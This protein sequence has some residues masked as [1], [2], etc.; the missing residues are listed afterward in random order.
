MDS[1]LAGSSSARP[2]P[3]AMQSIATLLVH[4]A[5]GSHVVSSTFGEDPAQN[6]EIM[7]LSREVP[8]QGQSHPSGLRHKHKATCPRSPR[9]LLKQIDG[10]R[11]SALK[12]TKTDTYLPL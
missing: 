10:F 8:F 2:A 12:Y 4:Y 5:I 9:P 6:H 11:D 3:S 7:P 1:I